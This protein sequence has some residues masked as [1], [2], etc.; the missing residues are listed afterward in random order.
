M[1]RTPGTQSPDP[2]TRTLVISDLHLGCRG[3]SSVLLQ[4]APR[5]RLLAGLAGVERLVLLGDT[6]EL[7][8]ARPSA[9]L[10]AALPVLRAIGARLGAGREVVL[11]PGN[12]DRLLIR[13]WLRER[14]PSL[15]TE[16]EVP[17]DASPPLR[18]L[19]EAL[20]AGGASVRVSYPGVW[21]APGVWAT[22]GHYL[23]QHLLPVSAYGIVRGGR[24]RIPRGRATPFDYERAGRRQLSPIGRVLPGPLRSAF[25]DVGELARAMTMPRLMHG[26]VLKPGTAPLTARLLGT[27]MRRH[28]LPALARVTHHLGIQAEWVIFGHVHRVGPLAGDQLSAWRGPGGAPRLANTGAWLYEPLLVHRASPPHPYWPGG[29]VLLEAGRP[30]RAVGLLDDL[31]AAELIPA[32]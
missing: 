17:A 12:H 22:H 5:E 13:A 29:A 11:V 9:A 6:V 23:D 19:V 2:F 1:P 24:R 31:S 32:R 18:R 28:S 30:P 21:L 25:D 26:T 27:Q 3:R 10:E 20:T 14:G 7:A 16:D 15:R 4:P 8:E